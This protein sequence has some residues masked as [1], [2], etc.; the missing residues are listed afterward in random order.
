MF[1]E[2]K[3]QDE[4]EY[5]KVVECKASDL[6]GGNEI[7]DQKENLQNDGLLHDKMTQCEKQMENLN[8]HKLKEKQPEK[9]QIGLFDYKVEPNQ[10]ATV[11]DLIKFL[12][13]TAEYTCDDLLL[14]QHWKNLA[15]S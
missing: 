11:K 7:I 2:K 8:L 12:E 14:C 15:L 13:E 4:T 5:M 9:L 6:L 1:I 10:N 3:L